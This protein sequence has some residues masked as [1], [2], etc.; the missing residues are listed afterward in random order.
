MTETAPAFS[1][2]TACSAVVTSIIT[3]PFVILA[4]PLYRKGKPE[5]GIRLCLFERGETMTEALQLYND[6]LE[7]LRKASKT[8][9]EAEGKS[10]GNVLYYDFGD[11]VQNNITGTIATRIITHMNVPKTSIV[12]VMANLGSMKKISARISL[13]L[14]EKVD[15]SLLFR[16]AATSFGGS[17]GGHRNAAGAIVPAGKEMEFV[18]MVNELL[19]NLVTA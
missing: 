9:E 7:S 3:P 14:S 16:Q 5:V 19:G 6:H 13:E 12:M 8:L 4:K 1:A 10:V 2:M 17:G 15:L 18:R 11:G